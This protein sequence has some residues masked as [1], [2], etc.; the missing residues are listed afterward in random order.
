MLDQHIFNG[1]WGC[2]SAPQLGLSTR[3]LMVTYSALAHLGL[4]VHKFPS[5]HQLNSTLSFWY[6]QCMFWSSTLVSLQLGNH[7][8]SLARQL[9]LLI[10]TRSLLWFS[11][12]FDFQWMG[13]SGSATSAQSIDHAPLF[14]VITELEKNGRMSKPPLLVSMK[15]PPAQTKADEGSVEVL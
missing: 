5:R 2:S 1:V 10:S 6:V 4:S 9:S 13:R 8:Q 15:L 11:P 3:P 14:G 12:L 7:V